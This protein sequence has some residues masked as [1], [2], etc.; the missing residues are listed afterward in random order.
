MSCRF[1]LSL[2]ISKLNVY[3]KFNNSTWVDVF[4][5]KYAGSKYYAHE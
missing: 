3:D 4:V 5:I 1:V 2:L